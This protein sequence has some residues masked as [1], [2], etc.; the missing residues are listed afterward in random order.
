MD[1]PDSTR[2]PRLNPFAF[3]SDTT[4][5]FVL[6]IVSVLG[7]SAFI[8]NSL[9]FRYNAQYSL[10]TLLQCIETAD[11]A[12]PADP[13][14]WQDA[15]SQC[16]APFDRSIAMWTIK[17]M[18]LLLSVAA[19]IFLAYPFW[20]IWRNRLVLL[21]SEDAPEII[22]YLAR[23]CHEI[24]LSHTPIFL[25]AP[26]NR[27]K[28]GLAFGRLGKYYLVLN[29]GL[30]TQFYKDREAFRAV[31]LHELA[32]L[33]NVDVDK[34]YFS[35]A[36]W[37]AFVVAALL[38]FAA[39]LVFRPANIEPVDTAYL[40]NVG[41]RFL[42]LAVLVYLTYKA[43]LRAREV[44]ADVRASV[45]DGQTGSLDRV[46]ATLHSPQVPRWWWSLQAHP[47]PNIRLR[48]LA[49]TSGLF[50]IGFWEAFGTGI[51][52]MI[53]F[54]IIFGLLS[55]L[56]SGR[57]SL[58]WGLTGGEFAALGAALIFM[59]MVAG[60]L[61]VGIWR[62][63]FAALIQGV[64]S[65][66]VSRLWLGLAL[67]AFLGLF[68]SPD[69]VLDPEASSPATVFGF[70]AIW[71]IV[72]LVYLLFLVQWVATT[73]S[74][75]LGV[76][77]TMTSPRIITIVIFITSG[78]LWFLI[79]PMFLYY[80]LGL[81]IAQDGD[82]FLALNFTL[83]GAFLVSATYLQTILAFIILWAFPLAS[84]L[85]RNPAVSRAA[86][87]WGFLDPSPQGLILPAQER[88][89]IR[90][91]LLIGLAGGLI[92]CGLM[93]GIYEIAGI[94]VPDFTQAQQISEFIFRLYVFA[95]LGQAIIAIVAASW[96]KRLRMAQGLFAAFV[97]GC[98]M[99]G[100]LIVL[101][102]LL[103]GGTGDASSTWN[104]FSNVIGMGT[105]LALPVAGSLAAFF[106]WMGRWRF[107][108]AQQFS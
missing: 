71:A 80:T 102:L 79:G 33:R 17:G 27:T 93:I 29:G 51:V 86:P 8:Y 83:F 96:V 16:K 34:A 88:M 90:P 5:R 58:L 105:L 47:D 49:D 104:F 76:T 84:L 10:E 61:V 108:R 54:S 62:E 1:L 56:T 99:T 35:V 87:A 30:I 21:S 101:L 41:L 13:N 74:A 98:V 89:R 82:L 67:G 18:A 97:A 2:P 32:H 60:V 64:S 3:P 91:A 65:G 66:G 53:S 73:A 31:V 42:A 50:R 57:Q 95:A 24:G 9:F 69:R 25:S 68:L 52:A 46:L 75:W 63:R 43:V 7:V 78:L 38:P 19:V 92:W 85:W 40:T 22:E 100:G 14:A 37:Q 48:T 72:L 11:A 28:S 94:G 20:K 77:I 103:T 6:L 15:F 59:P 44:Y 26:L 107:A 55:N 81:S 4:F 12:Q 36:I 106:E 70:I 39:S 45:Y 23:L